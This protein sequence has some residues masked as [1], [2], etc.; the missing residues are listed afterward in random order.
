[1]RSS[2]KYDSDAHGGAEMALSR[3][4]PS[5]R[6]FLIGLGVLAA[7]LTA[8][9][10]ASRLDVCGPFLDVPA[11]L[12]PFVTEI[13]VLGI[14]VGTSPTTFSPDQALTRGQGAVFAAKAFDQTMARS[15]RRAA[16]GRWGTPSAAAFQA[17]LGLT[18]I[19]LVSVSEIATD[20][21]DVWAGSS[22]ADGNG[23]V[24]RIRA[25]DG[26]LLDTWSVPAAQPVLVALGRIFAGGAVGSQG[27]LYM[28][29]PTQPP[30]PAVPVT[31]ALPAGVIGLAFDGSRIW[32]A[33]F[34][35]GGGAVSIVTPGTTTP[36]S[37]TTVTA[38]IVSPFDAVFDGTNVWVVDTGTLPGALLRLDA[39]GNVIQT[40]PVG[41]APRYAAFD[42]TNLWVPSI[43][44][45]TVSVVQASTG[46]VVATLSGNGMS[47]PWAV[48]FDGERV[49]VTSVSSR[50]S[51]FK[52]A[53]LS[54]LGW[55]PLPEGSYGACS[56][57]TNFWIS[58]PGLGIGRL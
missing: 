57:G 25:S 14:T 47:N 38:G 48:A 45:S 29:D 35:P 12:C 53:D 11:T 32:T 2:S 58:L 41:T 37:T 54:P 23:A 34:V 42:G 52:A 33:D 6:K 17:G 7:T 31:D 56:D 15:N 28:I 19:P 18:A 5:L 51:F 30:G 9:A 13:Y 39:S 26:R 46:V 21:A 24:S 1:M 8:G 20:G 4:Y 55:S 27:Y 36:W 43:N 10:G 3:R 44:D 16:L 49:L 40:V 22:D 50:V